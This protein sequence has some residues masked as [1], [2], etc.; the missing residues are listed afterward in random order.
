MRNLLLYTMITIAFAFESFGLTVNVDAN[1]RLQKMEGF[2]ASGAF[3]EQSLRLHND[4]EEIVEV[5]FNDL[6]LDLYRIQNRYNHLNTNPPW[7]QGWLGSKE[8]LAEAESV[9]G[10]D[11]KV[12]M[13]A[14]G[15]PANLKS[16][17]SITNGGTLAMSG[18]SYRYDDYAQWWLDGFNYYNNN[19]VEVD[20]VSIQ[21]EPQYL[22]TWASCI[23]DPTEGNGNAG[24]D[25]A[26]E[27]V[28]QKFATTFGKS[29]MPRFVAPEHQ[30]T[31]VS[32]MNE[33]VDALGPHYDRIYA[34]AHH[35]YS[36]NAYQ[37]P[38]VLNA[39]FTSL[40]NLLYKPLFQTEYGKAN[41]VDDDITRKLNLAKLMFNALTIE[42]VSAYFYWGLWWTTDD[43]EGLIYLPS[44]NSSTY[45]L[46]P[47]YYAFKHYSAFV[48]EGWRR[49]DVDT[50][51]GNLH[52]SAFSSP[53]RDKMS[54]II[55]NDDTWAKQ[56]DFNFDNTTV[57]GG[58]IYQSTAT[59]N[60]ENIG[61]FTPG[62]SLV[63]PPKSITTLDLDTTTIAAPSNPNIL[64]IAIDDLR[65]QLRT[66]GHPQMVTP[67]LDE[68]AQE[69]YQF[70]RAYCQEGVCGPSRASIMTG[71]RPDT[72]L[73]YKYNDDFRST[74]PWAYTI[75][76]SLSDNGYYSTGIGKIFHVINGGN[77][78]LSWEYSW[79]QGGGSYGG[80][81]AA[82]QNSA[83][84][85]SSMRDHDVATKA[86]AKLAD[87]KNQQPFFYGV[88]FVRPHLPFV[89]PDEYWDLY[90]V[91]DLVTPEMDDEPI[92]GLN[93]SY[94]A[95]NELRTYGGM[96][97]SGP[98][99]ANQEQNLIH[100]YYACV[101]FVDAQVGRL[102]EAL[103]SEGLAS[104]TIVVVWGDHG[105]H[106]GNHGQWCKHSN[107]E[108]DTRIPM[109]IKVPWM[110]GAT[111]SDALVEALDIYPT[112]MELCGIEQ[113]S[114]LQGESLVPLLQDPSLVGPAEAVSQ[115]PRSGQNVMG[116]SLRTDR[117]RYT[118]WIQKNTG[119]LLDREIYDHYLD[120][121]EHTNVISTTD[122]AVLDSLST[123]L[124][125][126]IGG[127]YAASQPSA[128]SLTS[129]LSSFSTTSV[130]SSAGLG[131]D[132]LLKLDVA[133]SASANIYAAQMWQEIGYENGETYT[134]TFS[135]RAEEERNMRVIWLLNWNNQVWRTN[136]DLILTTE[137][138][139]YTY[140]FTA[141]DSQPTAKLRFQ[142]GLGSVG[143]AGTDV[144]ID[145][146]SITKSDGT[147]LVTN[148]EFT[149]GSTGWSKSNITYVPLSSDSA[150]VPVVSPALT[151]AQLLY[152][153]DPDGDGL[154]N[155]T[156][157]A[158]NLDPSTNDVH[159][160]D[161]N[162]RSGLPVSYI[163]QPG[164]SFSV[165]YVRRKDSDAI[166]YVPEFTDS[167]EQ[168]WDADNIN[169]SL[170][171]TSD[172][173]WE[174]VRA[175]DPESM[176]TNSSRFGRVRVIF[177]P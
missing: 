123:Q 112:L 40:T 19:G 84:A 12:L 77:D 100:G 150:G 81:S 61:S 126:Y 25:K 108:L 171:D 65:P 99:T 92:N 50:S 175:S 154:D 63:F 172:P 135:A 105:Y 141:N 44:G 87:L 147:E 38:D 170:V 145:S 136:P 153:A 88:G 9:T 22:A 174:I 62:S 122:S 29:A 41:T 89:A 28:W 48:H 160:L 33:Y 117:Y 10:R 47:E 103:E 86:V 161:D 72:T 78:P 70:N 148:G 152:T 51:D 177:N 102:M 129:F 26:F 114:H 149:S 106:L 137:A 95:W 91:S 169:V 120:P 134:L 96:P 118:E 128:E 144:Y 7:Q 94:E 98:V 166:Q 82:Y 109:I 68:L 176:S 57:S 16:N 69:G 13:T 93:Y 142:V 164:D 39:D 79:L 143:V 155:A 71:L 31:G 42:N 64:M 107:F 66:Y 23:L 73:A 53:N 101:S 11:I 52:A 168:S 104:N 24:Y 131:D 80:N 1:N 8:I 49:L 116:Y 111:K 125:P 60:C 54:V 97:A 159:S 158:Y 3:G 67:N 121:M 75:P 15:P 56:W 55:V 151:G 37:N 133:D 46:L 113:P 163:D 36:G 45:Q 110:P 6:G 119:N 5:A 4:F 90:D 58:T 85:P 2:G 20:Y 35:L 18:G 156:E 115:Y 173:E 74:V 167:L 138:Q 21:N 140:T 165:D 162:Q 27:T 14:W 124:A 132:P 17:N 157:Y 59:N 130:V 30:S 146:V 139:T 83:N 76:M 43:G 32:K 34:F 127:P